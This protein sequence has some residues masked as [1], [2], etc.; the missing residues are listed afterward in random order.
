MTSLE[1]A[2]IVH[3]VDKEEDTLQGV[4]IE[5]ASK[6]RTCR[7]IGFYRRQKQLPPGQSS[8]VAQ[9]D[10]LQVDETCASLQI[11]HQGTKV[12]LNLQI[13]AVIGGIIRLK[14]N[15]VSPS[16]KRYEVS[17]VLVKEPASERFTVAEQELS[18]L[19]LEYQQGLYK[20][21]VT[22]QPFSITVTH[23]EKP[24][25]SV[26]SEG[27]LYFEDLVSPSPES[28]I[29]GINADEPLDSAKDDFGHCEKELQDFLDSKTT[30]VGLDFSL[31][32]FEHVYGIP[33]HADHHRLQDCRESD[34]YRLY[35]L[36][37]FGYGVH[38]KMGIYGTVPLLLAHKA[39]YTCGVFWHNASETMVEV[40]YKASLQPEIKD[41][42]VSR[43]KK[44]VPQVDLRW[45]SE[46][47]IVDVFLL[48]GPSPQDVFNQYA[49]LTGTQAFPP[50]FS[51]GYHQCRWNYEDE[52]DVE[53]VDSG[54][55]EHLIPYDVIW[56]DIEHTDGKRYFTWDPDKFPDPVQMQ[57]KLEKKKRKL[58]VISDP[59]IK[60][61]PNYMLY[62]E[63]KQKGFFVKD[64]EGGDYVGRCWPGSS[65]YLDFTNPEVR[66][67]YSSQFAL[68]AHKGYTDTLFIWNDM[69]EPAVFESPEGTMPKHAVH[70]QSWEHRDLH[71]LYG[72][73]QQMATSEGLIR[74]SGG[75]ERPFVLTRSFF[76][77]SQ[78]YGAVW[79][80]DNKAEWDY[81]KISI[82]MLVTLSVTGI[83]FCGADVGG[84]VGNPEPELLVRWYQAGSFQPF[85]R[86][87]AVRDSQRREPWLFG[88]NNTFLIKKAIEER[89]TLL[90]YW[91]L[92][93]YRAHVSA[94]PVMRPLWV[95]FPKNPEVFGVENQY[96]IGNALMVVPVLESGVSSL[97]VLYPGSGELWYNFRT[98][99]RIARQHKQ[100]VRV[101]LDEIPVYQR[102]GTIVPMHTTVGKS[103]GWMEDTPY[104]LHVALDSK[105]SASGELYIDDGHSF[106][107]AQECMFTFRRFT[108]QKNV[109]SCR[110]AD[111]TGQVT[112]E[113]ILKKVLFMGFKNRPSEV[114]VII[115]GKEKT[116]VDFT[117]NHKLCLLTVENLSLDVSNDWEI[118]IAK[119]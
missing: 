94:E 17:D 104:E 82:P 3:Q 85:F 43:K 20:L 92:L 105:G 78:R 62:A 109:L 118:H 27:L 66:D 32:G 45:M 106:Q 64:R 65:C 51:L 100:K 25:V 98:H 80:G 15:D 35:N 97:D 86:G 89:Y 74:R 26:N 10:T 13:I 44:A 83:S 49:Q 28:V 112:A 87:H 22:A 95:E 117:Y 48:L 119:S 47:G 31:H 53:A 11:I 6:F 116:S 93:F 71:N 99:E 42:P 33:E 91:Y 34:A 54:F 40:N 24:L 59:H 103:T 102:G 114:N 36:D 81:L 79:T 56:L 55:D 2:N 16:K 67:W 60:I 58:V 14:I 72:F 110:S 7:Q 115:A 30:S 9:L 108:L 50:R 73:Y 39:S 68:N 21:H 57:E 5:S 107:Y 12:P 111:N 29:P 38:S 63:A 77:G 46:S 41:A 19:T 52:A 96:M 1:S 88:E 61:D 113:S 37:V 23:E 8:Y 76:A 69:N 84:F 90:P 4:L 101:T 70:H 75:Q 18:S